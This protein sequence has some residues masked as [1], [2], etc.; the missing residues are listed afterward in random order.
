MTTHVKLHG[1][2]SDRFEEIKHELNIQM[3]Y[4]L[5]NPEVLGLLM[6]QYDLNQE[7]ADRERNESDR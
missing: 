6:A 7:T 4:E 2:K 3:G 5:A 1:T